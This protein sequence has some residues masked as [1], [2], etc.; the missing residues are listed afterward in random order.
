VSFDDRATTLPCGGALLQDLRFVRREFTGAEDSQ[1]KLR[2]ARMAELQQNAA[3]S[4]GDRGALVNNV[5]E[6]LDPAFF[7]HVLDANLEG[8]I[9]TRRRLGNMFGESQLEQREAREEERRKGDG[10]SGHGCSANGVSHFL[11]YLVFIRRMRLTGD[12]R[13]LL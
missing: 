7:G 11:L 13:A 3:T 10:G 5:L 4:V 8:V 2:V 6:D 1:D 9:V 12:V